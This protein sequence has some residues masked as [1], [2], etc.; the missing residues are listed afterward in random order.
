MTGILSHWFERARVMH[1]RRRAIDTLRGLSDHHLA[2]IGIERGEIDTY[3]R[4]GY[5]WPVMMSEA[6]YDFEASLQGCG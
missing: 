4:L 5:P 6:R 1:D 3:V 2:D